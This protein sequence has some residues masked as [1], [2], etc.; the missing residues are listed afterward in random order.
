[1]TK[2]QETK[3]RAVLSGSALDFNEPDIT[4]I[5]ENKFHIEHDKS[6]PYW[7]YSF[8]VELKTSSYEISNSWY[9][10]NGEYEYRF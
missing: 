5:A 10:D 7:G 4:E 1:M 2:D 8:D 3:L 9:G 6:N